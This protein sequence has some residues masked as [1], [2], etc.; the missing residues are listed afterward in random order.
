MDLPC[1]SSAPE[2]SAGRMSLLVKRRR[3]SCPT[4]NGRSQAQSCHVQR[5]HRRAKHDARACDFSRHGAAQSRR[6]PTD[7]RQNAPSCSDMNCFAG[8]CQSQSVLT[9]MTS[10]KAAMGAADVRR[11]GAVRAQGAGRAPAGRGGASGGSQRPRAHDG[12]P[13]MGGMRGAFAPQPPDVIPA[14][15]RPTATSATATAG[16][17]P[18]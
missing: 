14:C 15:H 10:P 17:A 8:V 5:E 11:G 16:A 3:W 4:P 18:R 7:S 6:V 12:D 9:S 13:A 2:N 1:G